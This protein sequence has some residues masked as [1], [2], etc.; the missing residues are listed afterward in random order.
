MRYVGLSNSVLPMRWRDVQFASCIQNFS[1]EIFAS[2][3]SAFF[4]FFLGHLCTL[5]SIFMKKHGRRHAMTGLTYLLA[6]TLGYVTAS[7]IWLFLLFS[8]V[9]FALFHL[10]WKTLDWICT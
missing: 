3:L 4:V 10:F 2:L 6:L 1:E 9:S 8:F 7:I 5:P